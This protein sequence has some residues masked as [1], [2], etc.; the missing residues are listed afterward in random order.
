MTSEL[1]PVA[2]TACAEYSPHL[3]DAALDR[4]LNA[5]EPPVSLRSAK[6]LLK[7]NCISAKSGSLPCT[8]GTLILAV[9]RRLLDQGAQVSIGDSPAFGTAA[10]VLKALNL[11]DELAAL[12]VPVRNFTRGVRVDLPG[13][14][15]AVLARAPME[16]DLLVNLPRVKAHVQLRLTL[17]V[18]NYF[19]C[20]VGFRKP[21]WHMAYGGSGDAEG[22]G[23]SDRLVRIPMALPPSLSI[24]DGVVAMHRS[25]PLDGVPYPLSL[26]AASTEPAAADRA[27]H[28]IL[29]VDPQQAPVMAA[30]RRAGMPGANFSQL[31]FPLSAPQG[32]RVD[33]FLVPEGLRPVRF[34][35]F[36]FLT[37]RIKRIFG[38]KSR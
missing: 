6:V 12:G 32:F 9:A 38:I 37:K 23:F 1:I 28:E 5:V 27:L 21:W 16:C 2:L 7:P 13:G 4:V 30:C 36:H 33:D 15:Q 20:L 22:S 10:S 8:E 35:P 14:G 31:A 18:K 3:L 17:A 34:N 24:I 11:T 29:Q 19:G 25:G 26:L